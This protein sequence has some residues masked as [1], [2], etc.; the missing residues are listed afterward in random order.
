VSGDADRSTFERGLQRVIS[1]LAPY[2]EEIVIIG[3]WVPYLHRAFGDLPNWSGRLSMTRE[4]DVLVP[5]ALPPAGRDTIA[6]VLRSAGFVAVAETGNAAVWASDVQQGEKIEFLVPHAGTARTVGTIVGVLQQPGV[7]AIALDRL[8]L[9]QRHT[10]QLRLPAVDDTDSSRSLKV[11]VPTL[12]AYVLNKAATF[13]A[14]STVAGSTDLPK[15]A[16]DLVY[17]HDVLAAGGHVMTLVETELRT[18]ATGGRRDATVVAR[19]ISG[20]EGALMSG[21]GIMD[22]AREVSERDGVTVVAAAAGI[23]GR[24]DDLRELLAELSARV[25][26][27]VGARGRR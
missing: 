21:G 23:R 18:I 2:A 20:L 13:Q 16:K 25:G 7:G 14:R 27:R 3:G 8:D 1:V 26:A 24:L 9:L 10:Q 4:V 15:R 17:L 12:G 22:A 19:A 5:R 11:R 6:R